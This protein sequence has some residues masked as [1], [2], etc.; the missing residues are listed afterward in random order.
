MIQL[1]LVEAI[2]LY[3]FVLFLFVAVI[4]VYTEFYVRRPQRFLGKQFL[5][6]CVYCGYTYLDESAERISECPRCASYNSVEDRDAKA[7]PAPARVEKS[8][9]ESEGVS[10]RNT[11]KRGRHHQ[12][13]RGPRRRR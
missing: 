6:R 8:A 9:K 10:T 12:R 11:S 7:G 3:A 2:T 5:W 4:T 13:R 1:E